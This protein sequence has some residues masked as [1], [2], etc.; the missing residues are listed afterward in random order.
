MNGISKRHSEQPSQIHKHPQFGIPRFIEDK[1]THHI[2]LRQ[3][4][5]R[6]VPTMHSSTLKFTLLSA[7]AARGIITSPVQHAERS[8]DLDVFNIPPPPVEES[9]LDQRDTAN[10]KRGGLKVVEIHPEGYDNHQNLAKRDDLE[11]R[12]YPYKTKNCGINAGVFMPLVAKDNREYGFNDAV[13]SFCSHVDGLVIP[14]GGMVA[15]L[16]Q[17]TGGEFLRLTTG[18]IGHFQ[19]EFHSRSCSPFQST[20]R[21]L[22]A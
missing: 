8:D 20:D 12:A 1:S 15:A 22:Q 16:V 7:L 9:H 21:K 18:S 19:G 14:G 2:N 17:S 10:V 3:R 6:K 11:A 13:S 5:H 4:N